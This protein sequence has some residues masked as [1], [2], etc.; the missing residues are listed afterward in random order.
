MGYNGRKKKE[1]ER[2]EREGKRTK[3]EGN[4]TRK[5]KKPREETLRKEKRKG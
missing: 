1:K 5:I 3:N 4:T 2:D